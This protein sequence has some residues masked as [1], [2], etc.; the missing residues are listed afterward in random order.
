MYGSRG[1][2]QDLGGPVV[3]LPVLAENWQNWQTDRTPRRPVD[4]CLRPLD[5]RPIH[6]WKALGEA[7]TTVI[8]QGGVLYYNLSYGG[9]TP[10]SQLAAIN[11]LFLSVTM[12]LYLTLRAPYGLRRKSR[13]SPR[14]Q[15]LCGLELWSYSPP[16][17]SLYSGARYTIYT[18]FSPSCSARDRY[19]AA[20]GRQD[21]SILGG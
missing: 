9:Y 18:P 4:S 13:H 12:I 3:S 15:P 14:P 21:V 8:L 2:R 10:K 17:L 16:M 11:P 19:A 7:V 5:P 20:T 1:R 6:R